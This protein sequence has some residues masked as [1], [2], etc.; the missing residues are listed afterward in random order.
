MIFV[1][2]LYQATNL[3]KSF[4]NITIL[5]HESKIDPIGAGGLNICTA[6]G[7]GDLE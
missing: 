4:L 2:F 6:G 1:L 5:E 7:G 3:I